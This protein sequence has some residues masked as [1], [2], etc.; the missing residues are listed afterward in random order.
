MAAASSL[1][2]WGGSAA[3]LGGLS[4]TFVGG[5]LAPLYSPNDR[6]RSGG[7]RQGRN[8]SLGGGPHRAGTLSAE[9]SVL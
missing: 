8:P 2:R 9:E 3:L 1:L 4:T 7:S 5:L 6:S